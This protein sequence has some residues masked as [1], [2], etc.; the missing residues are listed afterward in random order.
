MERMTA[1]GAAPGTAMD[2]A[3]GGGREAVWLAMHGWRVDAV[4]V[5]PDALERASGLAKRCGV[6]INTICQD[7]RRQPVLPQEAYGLVCVFRFL[8]RRLLASIARAVAPGGFVVYETF[9]AGDIKAATRG[10]THAFSDGE[11]RAAFS[12]F[13]VLISR[14][15]VRRD[16]RCFSQLLARRT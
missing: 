7:L 15:G 3:C 13:E 9:G 14:D 5:L 6:A 1:A 2:L 8:D 10:G 4:D 11:L 16:G 12:G